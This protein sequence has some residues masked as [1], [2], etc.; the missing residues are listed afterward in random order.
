MAKSA[1]A[2]GGIEWTSKGG[3]NSSKSLSPRSDRSFASSMEKIGQESPHS[4]TAFARLT[5]H[6]RNLPSL[7]VAEVETFSDV[8]QARSMPQGDNDSQTHITKPDWEQVRSRRL[9][10]E[11]LRELSEKLSTD[12]N[13]PDI[14][15]EVM[16]FNASA[17]QFTDHII[18]PLHGQSP[19][20]IKAIKHALGAKTVKLERT[21]KFFMAEN[22]PDNEPVPGDISCMIME[23]R[24]CTENTL[25]TLY[26]KSLAVLIRKR[27][28][29]TPTTKSGINH[30]FL[31]AW[32]LDGDHAK[33]APSC[34]AKTDTK[35]DVLLRNKLSVDEARK[36]LHLNYDVVVNVPQ[37]P[38]HITLFDFFGVDS[39][40]ENDWV[41]ILT[42]TKRF[43][44]GMR[45]RCGY[46]A[47]NKGN[48]KKAEILNAEATDR[49]RQF[50]IKEIKMPTELPHFNVK[51]KV[52]DYSVE[53]Y[54]QECKF[55]PRTRLD[56][57]ELAYPW[58][59]VV[60]DG[61]GHWYPLEML[62]NDDPQTSDRLT[63]LVPELKSKGMYLLDDEHEGEKKI[64]KSGADFLARVIVQKTQNSNGADLFETVGDAEFEF[65]NPVEHAFL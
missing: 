15:T 8:S 1:K 5:Y 9:R 11:A 61:R 28:T 35:Y 56:V 10:I 34:H 52:K 18:V 19:E 48:G 53:S 54:F 25:S 14:V 58:L 26:W 39:I 47:P 36:V 29:T 50:Q 62:F 45:V 42:I 63:Y 31:E 12:S 32:P 57:K 43:L 59:P 49:G 55:H 40:D 7:Y 22:S 37:Q 60:S 6:L 20:S 44:K 33:I 30:E 16:A 13:V 41:N 17:G 51:D 65:I 27:A 4:K 3:S 2:F 38:L 46:I 23:G 24:T 64:R 21:K